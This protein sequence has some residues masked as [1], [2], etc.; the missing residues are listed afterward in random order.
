M[1]TIKELQQ[2]VI[3][4]DIEAKERQKESDQRQK[5]AEILFEKN[6]KE[7]DQRHKDAVILF[8]KN[9]KEADQRHKEADQRR[10]EAD[11][12]M[13]ELKDIQKEA[14]SET[15]RLKTMI[16][17]TGKNLGLAAEEFFIN[18][19]KPTQKIAG[20]QY[21]MMNINMKRHT[22]KLDGEYDIVLVNGDELLIIEVKHK[23]NINDIDKLLQDQYPKFQKLFPEYKDY[24]HKLALAS[25][26]MS[27]DI[28]SKARQ[29]NIILLQRKGDIVETV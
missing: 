1:K 15:K 17:G 27:D 5:E 2:R 28:I 16:F 24:K 9:K 23:A 6:K 21:D 8:E 20:V 13:Q 14:A 10:K 12:S 7:A 18:S 29:N 4:L 25:F 26:H 11:Q 3:E 19:I 22:R